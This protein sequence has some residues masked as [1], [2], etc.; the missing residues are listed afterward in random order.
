M[1]RYEFLKKAGFSGGALMAVLA[2]CVKNEDTYI[3]AL[4]QSPEGS[5]STTTPAAGTTTP[6]TGTTTTTPATGTTTP[7]T[8]TTT[9]STTT[10]STAA[11]SK[12]LITTEALN[13]ISN[14]KLK[15]DLSLASYAKLKTNSGYVVASG[16]V[17]AL[18]KTGQYIAATVTCSH[19]PK[20]KV[21]YSNGE[22]FCPEHSARFSEAGAGLNSNG[23]K[24]L[25]VYK[26][27]SD[28]KTVVVY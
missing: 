5:T 22:W 8:G 4:V 6:A 27:A 21:I 2:S 18:S 26:V 3:E 15:L 17:I 1:T 12:Y 23:K 16:I 7:A 28:G 25:A 11:D 14:T 19:E 10:V 13:A 20:K 24:G 9:P